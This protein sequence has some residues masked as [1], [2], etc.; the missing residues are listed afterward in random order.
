MTKMLLDKAGVRYDN[1]DAVANADEAKEFGISKAPTMLV[2][3]GDSYDVY[4]SAGAIAGWIKDNAGKQH[5]E[6]SV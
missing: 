2:P 3:D 4:D 1:V 5:S 6:A